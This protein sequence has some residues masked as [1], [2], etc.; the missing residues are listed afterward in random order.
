M[1]ESNSETGLANRPTRRQ[2][3]GGVAIVFLGIGSV[4]VA[5]AQE[6]MSEEMSKGA[7][8]LL[9]YLHQEIEIK[10]TRQRIYEVLLDSKQFAAL[11]G[12]P[13]E[14]EREVGR[15]FHTFGG[16]IEGRNVELVPNQ[17]IVQAWRPA[18]WEPGL[19]SM[20]RFELK[21]AGEAQS[22]IILDHSGFPEGDFRH[23]NLGWYLRYWEPMKKFLG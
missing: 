10:A 8:G 7:E 11:T 12:M 18:S 9:T 13:A 4:P 2:M 20:V 5:W 15:A 22:K 6:K 19:Y 1:R 21:D 16:M 23:L 14:I 3:I 17:R